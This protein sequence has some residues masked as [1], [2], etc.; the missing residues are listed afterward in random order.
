MN[1]EGQRLP[2]KQESIKRLYDKTGAAS[3]APV[4]LGVH[5]VKLQAK[6]GK[7]IAKFL[8]MLK[9]LILLSSSR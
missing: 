6:T 5:M 9:P 1:T 3:A 8:F 4:V 7:V 2:G